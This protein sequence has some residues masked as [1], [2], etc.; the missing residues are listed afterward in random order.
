MKL[1]A[2]FSLTKL[3]ALLVTV[4]SF[5][6]FCLADDLPL[7]QSLPPGTVL[8]E[9]WQEIGFGFREVMRSQI[10]PPGVF[11]GVSHFS[12]IY[13]EDEELCQCNRFDTVISPDGSLL[14]YTNV[15]D[16]RLMLF[17]TWGRE[18]IRLSNE[19]VGYPT[20]AAWDFSANQVVVNLTRG[21]KETIR[22][23]F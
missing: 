5:S 22:V 15:A 10:N 14:I 7:E 12:F 20:R 6:N 23:P 9:R 2:D 18:R 17:R 11:E 16:G 8:Q 19:F 1:T 21:S 4:C 3:S 13:F